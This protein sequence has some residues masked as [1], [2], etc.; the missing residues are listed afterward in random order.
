[1]PRDKNVPFGAV[2][3]HSKLVGDVATDPFNLGL[4]THRTK[5]Q[6][7]T[8]GRG[9]KEVFIAKCKEQETWQLLNSP[10]APQEKLGVKVLRG[11]NWG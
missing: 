4:L 1:M 2:R 7:L 9:I 11:W 8:D 3:Q 10:L 6:V 5:E